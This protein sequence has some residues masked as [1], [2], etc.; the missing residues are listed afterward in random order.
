MKKNLHKILDL[1]GRTKE[2]VEFVQQ[3]LAI[4]LSADPDPKVLEERSRS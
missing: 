3:M 1:D 4:V 2:D